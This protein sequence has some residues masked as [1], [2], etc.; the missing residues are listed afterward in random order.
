MGKRGDDMV[1]LA[2]VHGEALQL[3]LAPAEARRTGPLAEDRRLHP[4]GPGW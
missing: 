2:A 4:R 1:A 3:E